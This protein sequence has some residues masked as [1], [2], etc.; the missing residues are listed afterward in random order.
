M[1]IYNI[2]LDRIETNFVDSTLECTLTSL[3]EDLYR[4]FL[5]MPVSRGLIYRR[6]SI[7]IDN[8]L[9][10]V[11]FNKPVDEVSVIGVLHHS[12]SIITERSHGAS[13]LI[14][15]I[16]RAIRLGNVVYTGDG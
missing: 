1:R 8:L 9:R 16:V 14:D 15:R 3:S 6:L 5:C 11:D 13:G 10:A 2:Y 7:I 12:L 4:A